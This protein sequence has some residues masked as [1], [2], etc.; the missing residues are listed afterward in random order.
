VPFGGWPRRLKDKSGFGFL[1]L[2]YVITKK[3]KEASAVIA[4]ESVKD[5]FDLDQVGS[6]ATGF[7]QGYLVGEFA[8]RV[9]PKV[10]WPAR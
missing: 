4:T 7:I 3:L 9:K 10:I 2:G 1:G 8:A 6:L 5:Q